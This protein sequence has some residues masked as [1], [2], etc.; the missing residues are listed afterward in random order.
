MNP[1][2]EDVV[3]LIPIRAPPTPDL[4]PRLKQ[5]EAELEKFQLGS[6][7]L[8]SLQDR[9]PRRQFL[10]RVVDSCTHEELHY[11]WERVSPM[12]KCDFFS[13]LPTELALLVLSFVDE[14]IALTRLER[15]NTRYSAL[16][17]DE[18]IWE[19]LCGCYGYGEEFDEEARPTSGLI[20]AKPFSYRERFRRAYTVGML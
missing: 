16:A 20:F 4:S 6:S 3:H 19:R 15:V 12:M 14:P 13:N 11:L 9:T 10:D 1:G 8:L 2:P 18:G 7:P 17:R 5:I